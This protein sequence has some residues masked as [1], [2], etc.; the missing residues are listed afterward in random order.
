MKNTDYWA[1]TIIGVG[2][3]VVGMFFLMRVPRE[4]VAG[5]YVDLN[6]SSSA[7]V[8]ETVTPESGLVEGGEQVLI[9]GKNFPEN[10][11]V[12]IGGALAE[13]DRRDEAALVVTAPET[14]Q[15][16]LMKVEV[17]GPDGEVAEAKQ[18]FL[19]RE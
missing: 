19:Y 17:Y 14:T 10:V 9:L 1:I 3:I 18:R 12:L 8:V 6:A 11:E 2:V 13:V 16:G 7:M 15:A 5:E 4:Q